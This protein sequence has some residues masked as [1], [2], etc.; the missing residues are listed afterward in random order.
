MKNS[1][2]TKRAAVYI[3]GSNLFYKLRDLEIKNLT[4]FSYGKFAYW[5]ARENRIAT[6]RYYIGAVR[7]KEGDEKSKRM[8][9]NQVRLFNHLQS[10]SEG[11]NVQRGYLMKNDGAY[12]EKGVD[13]R[14]AVDLL[15][16][17]YENIYDVAIL[18]SSDTD[19]IPAIQKVK[20]LGKKIEYVGFSHKPSY[21][22]IKNAS[23]TRLLAK[24]DVKKFEILKK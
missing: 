19:L 10:E 4:Y 3:D 21:G 2:E 22:L 15:A 24:E 17:A 11:F 9:E 20:Q 18:I 14:M 8:Q 6:K 23:E 16:G 13:V 5:L 12:H 1:N 7:T